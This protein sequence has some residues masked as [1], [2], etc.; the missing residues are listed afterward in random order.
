M[1]TLNP[2]KFPS[3]Q[4]QLQTQSLLQVK[5]AYASVTPLSD[6]PQIIQTQHRGEGQYDFSVQ[7]DR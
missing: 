4:V 6:L 1:L 2:A 3:P 7:R 5:T